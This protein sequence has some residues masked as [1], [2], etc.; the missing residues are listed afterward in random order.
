MDDAVDD[1]AN[2]VAKF[3]DS[4]LKAATFLRGNPRLT[5]ARLAEKLGI[6]NAALK[7]K[8]DLKRGG[9]T[10][11]GEWHFETPQEP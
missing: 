5:A 3:G 4:E 11:N 2:D 6:E 1:A 8:A 10:R 9:G 7:S